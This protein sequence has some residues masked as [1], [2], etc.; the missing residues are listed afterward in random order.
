[1]SVCPAKTQSLPSSLSA[2]RKLGSLATNWAHSK[3]SD[4]TGRMPRLTWVFAGRTLTLLVL[5]CCG[6]FYYNKVSEKQVGMTKPT[7]WSVRPAKIQISLGIRPVWSESL[8]CAQWVAKDPSFPHADREDLIR[9]GGCPGWSKSLVGAQSFCWFCHEMAH[10]MMIWVNFLCFSIKRILWVYIRITFLAEVIL[11]RT[12]NI[13]FL[14]RHVENYPLII[15]KSGL[16]VTYRKFPKYS[17]TQNVC[18]NHSK[19]WTMWFYHR[20]ASS[21]D[22]DGMANSVDPDQTAPQGAVWSGSALFAQA[23]LSK[24]LGSLRYLQNEGFYKG[25]FYPENRFFYRLFNKSKG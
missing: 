3:D 20:V 19:I 18:C 9:L 23:Y 25:F 1:M 10:L 5:S 14:W 16:L 24:N 7:K 2:W 11:M 6:S 15:I 22:A 8:L 12:H 21:K 4:Q 17:D 13:S